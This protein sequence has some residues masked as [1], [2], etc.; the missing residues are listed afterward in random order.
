MND[1]RRPVFLAYVLPFVLFL[2]GI[3]LTKW[4]TIPAS[5]SFLLQHPE[6]WMYPLQVVVCGG[7]MIYF[8]KYYEFHFER[9]AVLGIAA[10]LLSLALWVSPQWLFHA[11][12]RTEGFNPDLLAA[13]WPYLSAVGLRF[14]RLVIVVP[15]M[16]E[17]FW[18]G[19]LMRFLIGT[20]FEKVPFGKYQFTAFCVVAVAFGLEHSGPDIIPGIVT[21]VI[22]NALAIRTR[23]LG[24][25]VIAHA[26]TNLGLGCYI[27]ATKQWG[28]W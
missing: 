25:C 14:V 5:G 2:V 28:F 3:Q 10:G 27:M 17:I 22:Y 1:F 26:V 24:A 8:R 11:A 23:S 15:F 9:G 21:G 4:L 7:V 18:R 12:R 20:P 16:E 19:F 13:G 6:F